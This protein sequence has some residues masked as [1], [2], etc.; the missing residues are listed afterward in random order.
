MRKFIS[1][2]FF[3]LLLTACLVQ[4]APVSQPVA[5]VADTPV[6]DVPTAVLLVQG[7]P[8]P[9]EIKAPPI[10]VPS[11]FYLDMLNEVDG[12]AVTETEIIRTNDGGVTWY[13]VT[14]PTLASAASV[15]TTFLDVNHAWVLVPDANNPLNAGSVYRT[16]DGGMN[17]SFNSTPFG[18]AQMAFLDA[19]NGWAMASL[20][21]AAGSNAISVF[22][23]TDGGV[24]WTQSFTN[25]PN[26]SNSSESIPLGGLKGLIAPLNLQRA[27]VGGV[28]YAPSI[29]YLYRTDD[30]GRTWT[31]IEVP[32]PADVNMSEITVDAIK[33]VSQ[34]DGFMSLRLAGETYRTAFY[35][36]HDAGDTWSMMSTILPGTGTTEILA[37]Q[38]IVF[39]NGQQ[40]YVTRDAAQ[41][42]NVVEPDV[43]FG[44]F[45]ATMSFANAS[46]GWVIMSDLSNNRVLYKSTDGA[47]TWI[48]LIP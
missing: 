27:W 3:A 5:P 32:L 45:F 48:Q 18:S 2:V 17:W 12:W 43:T 13:V 20:G 26:L 15:S 47:K 33:F 42:W 44:D 16:Q 34:T 41:T 31:Q 6:V 9:A 40:F 24:T 30:A 28:V 23:T 8:V 29:V 10:A 35:V 14:P 4:P 39:Y 36:T 22:Q 11:I 19:N 1:L 25:D 46:T 38:E 37:A 7:T 21:V